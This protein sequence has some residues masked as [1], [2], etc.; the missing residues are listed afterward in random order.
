MS[1]YHNQNEFHQ[2]KG[3]HPLYSTQ[4]QSL[5]CKIHLKTG[6]ISL[7]PTIYM[8]SWALLSLFLLNLE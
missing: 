2:K 1:G 4:N 7:K 8:G 3:V 6:F 5:G